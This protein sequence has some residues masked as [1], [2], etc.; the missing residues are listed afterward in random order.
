VRGACF[1]EAAVAP[2]WRGGYRSRLR[3]IVIPFPDK[4]GRNF[5]PANGKT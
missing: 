3:R 4:I 1:F 5:Y 2:A